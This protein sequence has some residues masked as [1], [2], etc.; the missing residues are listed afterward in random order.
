MKFVGEH[1]YVGGIYII[2]DDRFREDDFVYVGQTDCF[3]ARYTTHKTLLKTAS[4]GTWLR[5][6]KLEKHA[7]EHGLENLYFIPI[8]I[9]D[10]KCKRIEIE[11]NLIR[12]IQPKLNT[13]FLNRH[14]AD[15]KEVKH[16][17][18]TKF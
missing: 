14:K 6:S 4:K 1:K 18:E 12:I 17:D 15:F 8:L 13:G 16:S 11:D 9:E 5:Y 3:Y 2:L 10:V 7:L